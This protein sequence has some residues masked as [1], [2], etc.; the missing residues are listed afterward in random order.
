MV[1]FPLFFVPHST[2]F[3]EMIVPAVGVLAAKDAK[4]QR[5][6]AASAKEPIFMVLSPE[7]ECIG[8]GFGNSTTED[9]DSQ[10]SHLITLCR[11]GEFSEENQQV[12]MKTGEPA[13]LPYSSLV[14]NLP[15]F[16]TIA[17]TLA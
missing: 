15:S 13:S 3:S 2:D 10:L 16:A 8:C 5:I 17:V 7:L 1:F 4:P 11:S 14:R 12:P 9:S 6:V